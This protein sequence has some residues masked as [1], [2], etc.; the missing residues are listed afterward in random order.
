[1]RSRIESI[2]ASLPG[3]KIF[4][5]GSMKH[6]V[7]AGKE[8][9]NKSTYNSADIQI[10]INAGIFRDNHVFEPA[11]AALIQDKLKIN[12]SF[13]G[14][15]SFTFDLINGGIGML[16]SLHIIDSMIKSGTLRIG[17]A[18]SSEANS[19]SKPDPN[20]KY[21]H[22]GAALILD[23]SPSS[24]KGFGSFLFKTFEEYKNL[25]TATLEL[26]K[27]YGRIKLEQKTEFIDACL[28]CASKVF[29]ELL[30]EEDLTCDDIDLVIPSQLS[31]N[32]IK[33]LP[34]YI[35]IPEEKILD[36]HKEFGGDTHTTSMVIG[37]KS[38]I[39]KGLVGAGQTVAFLGATSGINVGSAIYYL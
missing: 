3:L 39:D 34:G 7:N 15:Q 28:E 21:P 25:S 17:M 6:A 36:I 8:C 18:V 16:N 19:D 38:A 9:I 35:N 2:G 37:L 27:K 1:M 13:T 12:R 23:I 4:P 5:N 10:L 11:I 33:G 14:T 29:H 30:K 22:T 20:F 24:E 26:H 32:F 31:D